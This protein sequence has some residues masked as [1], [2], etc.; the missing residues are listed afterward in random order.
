MAIGG[1]AL[2][3]PT[4]PGGAGGRPAAGSEDPKAE[5]PAPAVAKPPADNDDVWRKAQKKERKWKNIARERL[6]K[7]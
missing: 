3:K 4:A 7:V 1:A 5:A 2:P 6:V